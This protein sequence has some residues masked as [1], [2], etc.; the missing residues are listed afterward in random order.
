MLPVDE[1]NTSH[2][3]RYLQ[4]IFVYVYSHTIHMRIIY[5]CF[6]AQYKRLQ[7]HFLTKTVIYLDSNNNNMKMQLFHQHLLMKIGINHNCYGKP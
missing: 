6:S 4:V 2:R 7:I 1:N 3:I 5:T